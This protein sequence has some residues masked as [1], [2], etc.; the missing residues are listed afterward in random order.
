MEPKAK[1]C[2]TKSCF[3]CQNTSKAWL[4]AI[5]AHKKNI[6]FRKGEKIFQEG[7][8]VNGI[9]FLYRGKVKVQTKWGDQKELILH[10][11]K[12]GDMIG[13]RGL[14]KNRTY[15]VSATALE[16]VTV[17]FIELDFFENMLAAN[18]EL[19]FQLM[20]FYATEMQE[21]ERRMRNLVHMDVKGRLAETLLLL[22]RTF[23]TTPDG[24]IDI[25]L[26]RQDIASYVGT[27]YETLFRMMDELIKSKIIATAG[28][29]IK[30]LKEEKL[31]VNKS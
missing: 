23:G 1:N 9:Y 31:G 17:C 16:P 8:K 11:S 28:K 12:A 27:T 29:K 10:F 19:T 3:L 7:E 14:G 25:I 24:Y 13:Y 20:K 2:D 22:K 5:A 18:H 26:T 21:A 6:E 4:P 30:I 15:P